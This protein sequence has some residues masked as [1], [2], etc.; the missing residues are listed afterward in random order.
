[1]EECLMTSPDTDLRVD[2]RRSGVAAAAGRPA[3][4]G[5]EIS[6][7]LYNPQGKQNRQIT[8]DITHHLQQQLIVG[9]LYYGVS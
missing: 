8:K 2:I 6:E 9:V 3:R 7:V 5:E 1:M 4:G